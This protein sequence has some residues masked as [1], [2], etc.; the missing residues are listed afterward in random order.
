[1][2]CSKPFTI[3]SVPLENDQLNLYWKNTKVFSPSSLSRP[4][5]QPSLKVSGIHKM[6]GPDLSSVSPTPW[7]LIQQFSLLFSKQSVFFF[8]FPPYALTVYILNLKPKYLL[9]MSKTQ[10]WFCKIR[11]YMKLRPHF[12]KSQNQV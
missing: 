6:Q 10:N 9:E 12:R 5:N 1:M 7:L 2:E 3:V 4:H 11:E 8:Q